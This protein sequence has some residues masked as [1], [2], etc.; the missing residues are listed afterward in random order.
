MVAQQAGTMQSQMREIEGTLSHLMTQSPEN[1][2][3]QQVGPLLVEVED[4]ET[5]RSSLEE[6]LKQL[7]AH[8]DALEAREAELRTAYQGAV[9]RMESA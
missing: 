8:V 9:E 5:L 7:S 2:I 1:A 6:T 3:Y 4:L